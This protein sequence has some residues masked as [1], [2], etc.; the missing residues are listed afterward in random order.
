MTH[1]QILH[2]YSTKQN[3][4]T[5]KIKLKIEFFKSRKSRFLNFKQCLVNFTT[6]H[7]M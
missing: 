2:K 3:Q 4:K 6:I 5:D 7:G 1:D